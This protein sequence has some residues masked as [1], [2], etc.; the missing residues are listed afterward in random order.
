MMAKWW[1]LRSL[2]SYLEQNSL[3]S[4]RKERIYWTRSVMYLNHKKITIR[5]AKNHLSLIKKF[6]KNR[7]KIS[8]L[9]LYHTQFSRFPLGTEFRET[10][11]PKCEGDTFPCIQNPFLPKN[12]DWNL[13]KTWNSENFVV[14]SETPNLGTSVLKIKAGTSRWVA[15]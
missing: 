14:Q 12:L 2:F 15:L 10:R 11:I 8:I 4:E 3:R 13:C 5:A 6:L 9:F 7:L 1:I